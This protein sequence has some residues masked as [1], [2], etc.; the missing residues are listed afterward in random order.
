LKIA[1]LS[2]FQLRLPRGIERYAWSLAQELALRDVEVDLLTWNWPRPVSWGVPHPRVRVRRMP[3]TRY[4]MAGAAV[5]YYAYWLLRRRYDWVMLFF[6]GYG[7]A[8]AMRV[9]RALRPQ[10]YAVV[11][12][13]PYEQVPHRYREF[14]RDRLA[15]R[16]EQRIAVSQYVARGVEAR[17]GR[18]CAVIGNGV[19]PHV[20]QP[21]TEMRNAMRQKLRL[22]PDAPVL[23]TVAALEER[24]GV[25]WVIRA[26]QPLLRDFPDLCYV[27][28]GEGAYRAQLQAEIERL[29][30]AAHVR[31]MGNTNDVVSYLAAADVGCLLSYGEAFPIS[32]VELMAMAL[33]VLSSAHPPFD[34]LMRPDW[35]IMVDE[36]NSA[37]VAC[38]LRELLSDPQRRQRMGPAGRQQVMEHHTWAQVAEQYLALLASP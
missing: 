23:I 24:K 17:F 33:P 37:S 36:T 34:E 2:P 10:R 4:F 3:Y 21:S 31:L 6:A 7:E 30:L 28:L 35:G 25:Q 1:M 38:A 8:E 20:F 27:V 9:L 26:L 32:L 18:P 11:F 5:A 12:Q 22:K 14:E 16:A 15:Q 29:G 19:D 13:F